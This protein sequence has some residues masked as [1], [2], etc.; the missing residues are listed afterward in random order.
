MLPAFTPI[1]SR[2]SPAPRNPCG[3][4]P[5]HRRT[6]RIRGRANLNAVLP[7]SLEKAG[8]LGSS[9]K[10][11]QLHMSR[12]SSESIGDLHAEAWA[13]EDI[14]LAL[15]QAV[16]QHHVIISIAPDLVGYVV[17]QRQL[18]RLRGRAG[19]H[20]HFAADLGQAIELAGRLAHDKLSS[21]YV[22]ISSSG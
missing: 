11:A 19:V 7:Q 1:W 16:V 14:H 4:S 13:F 8:R 2:S 9:T 10:R 6:L 22:R 21:G 18:M 15:E 12:F 17:E 3:N 20:R 5:I